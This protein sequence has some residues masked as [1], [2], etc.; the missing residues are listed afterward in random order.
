M[1]LAERV[2]EPGKVV[3][4]ADT[5]FGVRKGQSSRFNVNKD[6]G[7]FVCDFVVIFIYV[8]EVDK[9]ERFGN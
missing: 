6:S 9:L 3:S 2:V 8:G 4:N 5:R 7:V 1:E